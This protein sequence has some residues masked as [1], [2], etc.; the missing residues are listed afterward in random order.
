MNQEERNYLKDKRYQIVRD[1]FF[2][3]LNERNDIKISSKDA[4]ETFLALWIFLNKK[5]PQ[6][7]EHFKEPVDFITADT[8]YRQNIDKSKES[9][10]YIN[11]LLISYR[12]QLKK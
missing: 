3:Y 9:R 4:E 2:R 6:L 1:I 12:K 8:F 5:K 7:F 11:K 10:E